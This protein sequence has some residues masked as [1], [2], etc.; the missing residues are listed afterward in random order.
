MGELAINADV[1]RDADRDDLP[2]V[3]FIHGGALI[4]GHREWIPEWLVRAAEDDGYTLVSLDY[5]LAPQTKLPEIVED[6]VDAFRWLRDDSGRPFRAD[7][8]RVA[9]VG[10]SAGGYLTLATGFLV[11]PRPSA[12]ISFWGYGDL[13]GDWYSRPSNHPCHNQVHLS[14]DEAYRQ[15]AGPPIADE[16]DRVGDGGAFYQFCRQQGT[17]PTV[18]SGWDP[19]R[20]ADA[21]RMFM[22]LANVSSDYPP[23]L[24]VHG[25]RD[26]D[27]PVEQSELM[28]AELARFGVEHR[29]LSVAG[30]EH[31][32][33]DVEPSEVD[34]VERE[35]AEFLKHHLA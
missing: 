10:E 9:V 1:Y 30:G 28:A 29:L 12:L 2:M 4:N 32:L 6:V 22:P 5:R 31:G 13:I 24:L 26:T 35:A 3:V 8:K 25:D 34:A 14:A 18:V 15:V 27:V 16:R 23:T 19:E 11:D 17:W 33:E 20:D 21:F 7:P